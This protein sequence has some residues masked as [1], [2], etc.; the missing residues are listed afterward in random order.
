MASVV[1]TAWLTAAVERVTGDPGRN[2]KEG[3]RYR[4]T[5]TSSD[6]HRCGVSVQVDTHPADARP[7][8][9]NQIADRWHVARD[10]ILDVLEKW[11]PDQLIAHLEQF[12]KKDPMPPNFRF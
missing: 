7:Y 8:A 4:V 10:E 1:K 5:V 12:T 2:V 3:R 11:T 9:V 6:G